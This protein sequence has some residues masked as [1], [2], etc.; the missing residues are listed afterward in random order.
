MTKQINLEVSN[1]FFEKIKNY[2]KSHSFLNIQEFIIETIK[3]KLKE[4]L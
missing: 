3:E 1:E 2:A 4:K